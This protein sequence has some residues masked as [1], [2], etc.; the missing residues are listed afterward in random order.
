[1]SASLLSNYYS[2]NNVSNN[3]LYKCEHQTLIYK[4]YLIVIVTHF[5]LTYTLS[6][7]NHFNFL[8]LLTHITILHI[9]IH[10]FIQEIRATTNSTTVILYYMPIIVSL[11]QLY[12]YY[13]EKNAQIKSIILTNFYLHYIIQSYY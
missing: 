7:T 6:R 13:P 12:Y 2:L 1:M 5:T 4:N 3:R 9:Y 11:G 10:T 8:S